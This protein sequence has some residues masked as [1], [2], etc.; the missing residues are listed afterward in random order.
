MN[1]QDIEHFL[2]TQVACWNSGDRNGFMAAYR[3]AGEGGLTIEYV[4]RDP[5]DGWPLLEAM[6]ERQSSVIAIEEVATII[7][8]SEAA[9]HNRNR[10]KASGQCIDTI[11]V[12][13]FLPGGKLEVRYFVRHT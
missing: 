5:V 7:N 8:G 2:H 4:G 10:I 11:E 3:L 6:W 12:Y 9:C 13:R 1:Q